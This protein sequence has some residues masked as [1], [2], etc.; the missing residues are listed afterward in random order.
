MATHQSYFE[1][2]GLDAP[3]KDRKE[4][5][6]AYSKKL[7]VT[8]PE[9]DPEGFMRLRDAHDYALNIIA[10]D[11]QNAAWEAEQAQNQTLEIATDV[12]SHET[13][14]E[15]EKATG[16]RSPDSPN[17][18]AVESETSYSIGPVPSLDAPSPS[19]FDIDL[20]PEPTPVPEPAEPP[21]LQELLGILETPDQYND[22]EKWN[23]LFRQAR[24]LDIDDY[25]DFEDLLLDVILRFHGYF[26]PDL[27]NFDQPEKLPQKLSPSISASLF[28]T[29]SWDKVARQ[30]TRQAHQIEWLS[31]RM[32]TNQ[33]S[34]QNFENVNR[35][36]DYHVNTTTPPADLTRWFWPAL[37]LITALA[38]AVDLMS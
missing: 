11:A 12:A 14:L 32:R 19:D 9:D 16:T 38:L 25:V 24:Q 13:P 15:I 5:K 21:L 1:I 35:N 23:D 8:R 26:D 31:R 36:R 18:E 27:P 28:K 6:R 3:P 22:R 33:T 30:G 4:V 2:L 34:L 17:F 29:M 20:A 10:H 37:G 7:K